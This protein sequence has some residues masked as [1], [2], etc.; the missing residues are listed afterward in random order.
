M[1]RLGGFAC[2]LDLDGPTTR[3][4]IEKVQADLPTRTEDARP[5]AARKRMLP[6]SA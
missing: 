2:E 6:A 3:A 5:M 1:R 4:I